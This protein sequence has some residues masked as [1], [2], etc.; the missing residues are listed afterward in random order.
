MWNLFA[1]GSYKLLPMK[2]Y[3]GGF[4]FACGLFIMILNICVLLP[5]VAQT[6]AENREQLCALQNQVASITAFQRKR[7]DFEAYIGEINKEYQLM[8]RLLPS[9]ESAVTFIEQLEDHA[10]AH[11]LELISLRPGKVI[12]GDKYIEQPIVVG[13]RGEYA[14]IME[15]LKNLPQALPYNKTEAISIKYSPQGLECHI[16]VS[17]FYFMGEK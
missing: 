7:E 13:V 6:R 10:E 4:A 5:W 14:S 9:D 16:N 15:F 8:E 1:R 11:G 17:I 12:K 2:I 3:I